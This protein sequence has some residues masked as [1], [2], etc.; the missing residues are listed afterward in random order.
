MGKMS[1]M[2][3]RRRDHAVEGVLAKLKE[4]NSI[5]KGRV[6]GRGEKAARV[7]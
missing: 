6:L 2:A 4:E 3:R 5:F 7:G 1:V